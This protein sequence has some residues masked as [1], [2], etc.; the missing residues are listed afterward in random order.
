[1]QAIDAIGFPTTELRRQQLTEEV[2]VAVPPP[3]PIERHH[4]QVPRLEP[5]SRTV[6]EPLRAEHGVAQRPAHGVEH[7]G[8]REEDR[9]LVGD[10]VEQLGPEVVGHETVV[11]GERDPDLARWEPAWMASAAR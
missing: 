7:R 2:V 10:P 5:F 8:A 11:A 3:L 9:L 4:E 6:A 1:M